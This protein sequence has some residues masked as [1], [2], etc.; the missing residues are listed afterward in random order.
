MSY[1]IKDIASLINSKTSVNAETIIEHL[2]IDS[3][4]IIFPATSLFFALQGPRRNGH[5]FIP[6]LY[7]KGVRHFVIS[8]T[9]DES[10]FPGGIFLLVP[11]TLN[12]LQQLAGAHRKQFSIPVIGITGSNGKT[13]VKEWMNQLL[14]DNYRIIRNPKSYNSQIGVPLSVWPMNASHELGIFEAGISQS[15]EMDKLKKIIQPTIG[16]FTNIGEAHGENFLNKRQKV[17]EKLRLFTDV[18]VLVYCKDYPEIHESIALL[19]QQRND[20][21]SKPFTLINWSSV[22][23]AS[24]QILTI[25]KENG[26]TLI[27]ASWKDQNQQISI[28]FTD[29]ASVENAIHCW[30]LL[31]HLGIKPSGILKRMKVLE[32]VS[33]RLELKNGINHCT[34]INDSYSADIS[35]LKIALDFLLQQQQHDKRTLILSDILQSGKSENELYVEVATSLEQRKIDRFIG[36]GERLSQHQ[37]FF[38]KIPGLESIFYHTVQEFKNDFNHLRF[39]DETILIKGARVFAF[40]QIDKL[41]EQKVHQTI[42]EVNLTALVNNLKQYQQLLKEGT[43]LMV[44]VKAFAY[45][46]GSFEIASVLQYHKVDYLAVAYADEGVELRKAGINLPI[47]IMNPDESAF[48]VMVENNLEP[49]LFSIKLL[50]E[51]ALFLHKQ[52]IQQYPVHIELETGMNR[53]GFSSN[54]LPVVLDVLKSNA[55]K[56]QSIFSHLVASEDSSQDS[57]TKHQ[58]ELFLTMSKQVEDIVA[59]PVL[60]HIANTSGISRHPSLQM[61][62]VRLGIGLYGIDVSTKNITE[63]STLRST[64]AQLKKLKTGETVGY[65]RSGILQRDSIIATIRIGYADGYPRS[66]SRGAGKIWVNGKLAPIVGAI[67]MDMTMIDITDIPGVK[68]GDDVIIFGNELPVAQVAQWAQTIPYEILTG[69]SQRVK[70]VYFEE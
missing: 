49:E 58:A 48:E 61:D 57:F 24:L 47:M 11:D 69:V 34:V 29:D 31:L 36:I 70:R 7:E 62:M 40:E 43:H 56:V 23:D 59:Y 51:F 39:K 65:S 1:T 42:L 35:S 33:M 50:N 68:E 27:T 25:Y 2:L 30:C 60:K 44:M 12:S 45:G 46:S 19:W 14:E 18:E 20:G 10:I 26:H 55:F 9:T 17:N 15:G 8:E 3:R 22:S 13:I 38:H 37:H 6:E 4:K 52:G 16:I 67:C 32:A 28:P 41:L 21:R 5:S 64:I 63:V 53:L 54:E 66:L